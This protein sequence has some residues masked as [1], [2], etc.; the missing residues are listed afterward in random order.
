VDG[1]SLF[2]LLFSVI[3]HVVD[4]GANLVV[5]ARAFV[6]WDVV[7]V[8]IDEAAHSFAFAFVVFS[9]A[10]AAFA[11]SLVVFSFWF[12]GLP[13]VVC[14]TA[15]RFDVCRQVAILVDKV[16]GELCEVAC[17]DVIVVDLP[18]GDESVKLR[19][20]LY[21]FFEGLDLGWRCLTLAG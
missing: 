10:F 3:D 16:V 1:H 13:D 12:S 20:P 15:A 6:Y 9:F 11:F 19:P 21:R 14:I 17:E 4:G 8:P 2:L 18:G 5:V 7:G